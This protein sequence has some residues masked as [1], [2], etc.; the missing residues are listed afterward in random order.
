MTRLPSLLIKDCPQHI[1]QRSNNRQAIF[2]SDDG[3]HGLFRK[4]KKFCEQVKNQTL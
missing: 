4:S 1:I 2:F 3:L